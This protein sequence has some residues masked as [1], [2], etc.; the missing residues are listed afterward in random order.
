MA[1]VSYN[2]V[3]QPEG[4]IDEQGH[5]TYSR[6]FHVFSDDPDDGPNTIATGVPVSIYQQ[7]SYG[8]DVD[9]YAR[10]KGQSAKVV[11]RT[12]NGRWMW[13]YTLQYDT[14][15]IAFGNAVSGSMTPSGTPEPPANQAPDARPWVIKGTGVTQTKALVKDRSDDEVAVINSAYMPFKDGL[16]VEES[17]DSFSVT[18]Y[19]A[20]G[21][22]S[23]ATAREYRNTVNDSVSLGF[24]EGKLRCTKYDWQSCYEQGAYY[25][26]LD[27]EFQVREPDWDIQVLDAGTHEYDEVD[28]TYVE[29]KDKKTGKA[30][31]S[32]VPL[33]GDGHVLE[34]LT[35]PLTDLVYLVFRGY[36]WKDWTNIV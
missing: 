23:P 4:S 26:Q 1:V 36:E 10:C 19:K 13:E 15:P 8:N 6:L 31:S 35:D 21:S 2:E 29:I 24:S 14:K 11:T 33:D 34:D 7:Y 9:V 5:R 30:I 27:L 28:D 16:E 20:I 3:R 32:P 22:W 25:W 17:T 12:E 18:L